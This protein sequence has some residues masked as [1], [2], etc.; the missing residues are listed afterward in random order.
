LQNDAVR[1]QNAERSMEAVLKRVATETAQV[2]RA[3]ADLKQ[4]NAELDKDFVLK[5]KR[6][7]LPKQGALVGFVLFAVRSIID[8][9]AAVSGGDESHLTAALVQAAIAIACAAF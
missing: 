9:V 8:S 3:V 5:L 2:E 1:V 6:G 7:G 4:A